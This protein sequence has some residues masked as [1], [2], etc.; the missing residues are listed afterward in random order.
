MKPYTSTSDKQSMELP[1]TGTDSFIDEFFQIQW[2]DTM[3]GYY[4]RLF[5]PSTGRY[6][7][8]AS[9]S[10]ATVMDGKV[11]VTPYYTGCGSAKIISTDEF[12]SICCIGVANGT[13]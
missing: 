4:H 1:V 3:A 7:G 9:Y 8:W 10:N 5:D 12:T 2:S 13:K 11:G 6:T